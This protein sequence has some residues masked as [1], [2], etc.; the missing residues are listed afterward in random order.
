MPCHSERSEESRPEAGVSLSRD[1]AAFPSIS[2]GRHRCRPP[3]LCARRPSYYYCPVPCGPSSRNELSQ[4]RALAGRRVSPRPPTPRELRHGLIGESAVYRQIPSPTRFAPAL[5]P[6]LTLALAP[7][8]QAQPE[9]AI[10]LYRQK[11]F[12]EAARVLEQHLAS[13]PDDLRARLLL[14]LCYQEAGDKAG[15][16]RVFADAVAR[17]PDDHAAHYYLAR[18]QYLRA[19]FADAAHV[20]DLVGLI[21][22][23]Q[24]DNAAALAAYEA[25]IRADRKFAD[26]Y[27][28]AGVLLLKLGRTSDALARLNTAISLNP[29]SADAFYQRARAR[30]ELNKSAEAEKDLVQALSLA[31]YEPARRLLAQVRAGG[32]GMPPARSAPMPSPAP[33]RFRDVAR[34]AGLRFILENHPTPQKHLIETMPGGVA[35]FDYNNDGLPDIYFTNGASVP[36][37]E[38]DARYWN[39]LYRNDGGMKFTDVTD[40]AGLAAAGYSMGVAAADYDNDGYVDLFVAGVNH[41]ILYR[42]TGHGKF[43]DVTTRAGLRSEGWSVAA[44][45]FDY[46]NDGFLDLF[47]VNYVEWSPGLDPFCGG[48]TGTFRIYC[49]PSAYRGTSNRL[50]H[51]RGDGTFEDVSERAGIAAHAGKGMSAAFAD[52]DGDGFPDIFVTNDSLPNFLFHNHGDGTFEE[53]ALPAGVGLTDNGRPVSS[54][55]V[56]FRDYDNDGLPDLIVTALA[57]ETFPLFRN[58]GKGFFRDATYPSRLG[59][60]SA[61][62]S[63]WSVGMFDFNND[64]WKDVFSAN[65]HVTDNIESFSADRYQQPNSVFANLGNGQF[66]DVSADAGPDFQTPRAHRGAAF[67]DFN[68]DGKIDV[69]VSSLGGPAELWENV[70]PES[71]HWMTLRLEGTRSN[72]DGIGAR[73][74]IE[75]PYGT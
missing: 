66:A 22:A 1:S 42:N 8:S 45:W 16:E 56:D 7:S 26:A 30:L 69:V 62:R 35:A 74:R 75:T 32:V 44:G 63:G 11:K 73:I 27:L 18:V 43:E 12:G 40:E 34:N 64:G 28:N 6:I 19:R 4:G 29:R 72:R 33:I 51:N 41:N 52:Y 48:P 67:A 50:Y 70:S 54:M 46:D 13:Q 31:R 5:I 9:T 68:R 20:Y 36:S 71:N 58:E 21:R 10:A 3:A 57:R 38:K 60:A 25:A 23:E 47:V 14:G 17:R 37:L 49:H 53:V 55:G 39:R 59:L 15:A 65:A 24:N 2:L 61:N